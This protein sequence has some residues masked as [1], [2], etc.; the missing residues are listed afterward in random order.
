[1][2]RLNSEILIDISSFIAII[3]SMALIANG[4]AI[5]WILGATAFLFRLLF[6]LWKKGRN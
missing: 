1:M 4:F 2:R 6:R 3:A 5:G